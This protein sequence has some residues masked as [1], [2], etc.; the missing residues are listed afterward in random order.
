MSAIK[1]RTSA[2][3]DEF[4]FSPLFSRGKTNEK[5]VETNRAA[6]LPLLD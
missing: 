5:Q 3:D 2:N 1:D 6:T 4:L